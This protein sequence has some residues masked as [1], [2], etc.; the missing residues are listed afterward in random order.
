M[1]AAAADRS[2][3]A[4]SILLLAF[5]GP[6][7]VGSAGRRDAA[8]LIAM[9]R[10]ATALW[11]ADALLFDLRQLD[12]AWGDDI[13]ELFDVPR[14]V[15]FALPAAV[16]ASKANHKPLAG[17]VN[18]GVG[19]PAAAIFIQRHRAIAHLLDT[20]RQRGRAP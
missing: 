20:L 11:Y 18:S 17:I 3:P 12:Y 7:G 1:I 6:Y 13:C 5:A 8:Y 15:G 2:S 14:L 9:S 16:L 4:A 19:E 10:A